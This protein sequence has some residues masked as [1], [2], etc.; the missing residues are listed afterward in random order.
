MLS[1][2]PSITQRTDENET[3]GCSAL[4]QGNDTVENTWRLLQQTHYS[5]FAQG[6][7]RGLKSYVLV[8]ICAARP[9]SS[10]HAEMH[11]HTFWHW[12]VSHLNVVNVWLTNSSTRSATVWGKALADED[13]VFGDEGKTLSSLWAGCIEPHSSRKSSRASRIVVSCDYE[14]SSK[15]TR[16]SSAYVAGSRRTKRHWPSP[17]CLP[18]N[19]VFPHHRIAFVLWVEQDPILTPIMLL[20]EFQSPLGM[21]ILHGHTVFKKRGFSPRKRACFEKWGLSSSSLYFSLSPWVSHILI[22]D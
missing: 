3:F 4:I 6:R 1:Q 17:S 21:W 8:R 20:W 5:R 14:S 7:Q 2:E 18:T 22:H 13:R 19:A 10:L 15:P 12:Y 16:S 9:Q 11:G